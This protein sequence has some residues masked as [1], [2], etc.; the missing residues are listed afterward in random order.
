MDLS[1][2]IE[3]ARN[4]LLTPATEWPVIAGETATTGDLYKNY[5]LIL[6]AVPAVAGLIGMGMLGVGPFR[7]G[8]ASALTASIVGYVLSL[9]LVYVYGLVINALAPTFGGQKDPMQA[10][11]TVVYASTAAWVAGIGS[12]IPFLGWLLTL[13]GALYTIYLLYLGLPV[14]MKCP[15][16][17]A[18]GYTAVSVIVGILLGWV[19]SLIVGGIATGG[20][21]GGAMLGGGPVITT[22]GGDEPRIDPNSSLGKLEQWS[23]QVEQAGKHVEA[24]EKSGNA[25]EMG[26]AVGGVLGAVLGGGGPPVESLPPERI[27]AFLPETLAG[28][29]RRSMS[30]ERNQAMGMQIS[31]GKAEYGAADGPDLSLEITDMGSARGVMLLAGWAG[32]ESERQ[33][34]TGYEKTAKQDGRIVHEEWNNPGSRGEYMVVLGERFVAKLSGDAAS[35]DAL[36]SALGEVD[37]GGLEALKNEGVRPN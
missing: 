22:P 5:V 10:L 17:K 24:A 19:V 12:V 37:L 27:K 14:T 28:L 32:V 9:I 31:T 2:L 7:L 6:A 20:M 29:P 30:A 36:K 4:I 15:Q 18:V 8:M 26:K 1:K 16:D 13:A 3:R 25:D 34:D 23:K 33:T 11:K 35:L 21:M